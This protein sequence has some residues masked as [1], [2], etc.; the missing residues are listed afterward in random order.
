MRM[1]PLLL[2][3]LAIASPARAEDTEPARCYQLAMQLPH[4]PDHD[5]V[6]VPLGSTVCLARADLDVHREFTAGAFTV[7]VSRG[8]KKVWRT[9]LRVEKMDGAGG[10]QQ[11]A[12]TNALDDSKWD[13]AD[14]WVSVGGAF[15]VIYRLDIGAHKRGDIAGDV[16]LGY[17]DKDLVLIW[18]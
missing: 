4:A 18:Q 8:G 14:G 6:T 15:A 12:Y 3:A 9:I 11:W 1:T 13:A 5:P 7:T 17:P 2:A 16:M 10:V